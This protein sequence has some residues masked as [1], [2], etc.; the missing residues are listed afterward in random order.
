MTPL[1]LT[2]AGTGIRTDEA[3]RFCIND[4]HRLSGGHPSHHPGE[5]I[6]NERTRALINETGRAEN[7]A[8]PLATV[9]DG[10]NNGTYV[11]KELVNAYAMW[12]SPAFQLKVIR[13]S[14]V[15]VLGEEHAPKFRDMFAVPIG[16]GATRQSPNYPHGGMDA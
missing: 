15:E 3:G 5:W 8:G 11:A 9:N 16:N 6:R 10:S 2:I 13:A 7:S 12:I 14:G 4:L 1:S